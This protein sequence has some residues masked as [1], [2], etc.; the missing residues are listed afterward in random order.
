M[1]W[2]LEVDNVEPYG[3]VK[4]AFTVEECNKIIEYGNSKQEIEG[5]IE[6]TNLNYSVRK[7][8]IAWL[9]QEEQSQWIYQKLA[10]CIYEANKAFFN[11][12]LWGMAEDLQFTKYEV[13]SVHK[14]H[15]DLSYKQRIRKLT[16]V[17]QLTD[18][19]EYDGGEL[20]LMYQPYPVSMDKTQGTLIIFPSYTLHEVMP[21]TRGK[22]Y[23]L[24]SWVTGNQFK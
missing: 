14:A 17:V 3:Y 18:E 2:S 19:K 23:S 16:V 15:I 20:N 1:S 10:D 4:K 13:G 7:S 11:F 6:K 24:V 8:K 21:L 12:D 22:R 9:P 5:T